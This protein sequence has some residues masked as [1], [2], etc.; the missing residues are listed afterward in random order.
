M[1]FIFFIFFCF[2]SLVLFNF[3]STKLVLGDFFDCV[4][5]KAIDINV[6]QGIKLNMMKCARYALKTGTFFELFRQSNI[7][8]YRIL[9]LMSDTTIPSVN[10]EAWRLFYQLISYHSGFGSELSKKGFFKTVLN[11]FNE[12]TDPTIIFNGTYYIRKLI[13]NPDRKKEG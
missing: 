8:D 9:Q 7:F 12:K 2:F 3:L 4:E 5:N 10:K 6:S 1:F 13:E 11:L